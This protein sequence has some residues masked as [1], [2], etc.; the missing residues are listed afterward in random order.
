[1]SEGQNSST[2]GP[3]E[4]F[5]GTVVGLVGFHVGKLSMACV[6]RSGRTDKETKDRDLVHCGP[7]G[8]CR[9]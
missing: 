3:S 4:A 2:A 1:M 7:E 9:L 8:S 5:C 6:A